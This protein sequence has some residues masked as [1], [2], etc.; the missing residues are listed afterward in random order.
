M[1]GG[2]D[3]YGSSPAMWTVVTIV[4]I[5]FILGVLSLILGNWLTFGV[6]IAMLPLSLI[7]GKVMSSIG[8]QAHKQRAPRVVSS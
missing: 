5:A 6:A 4:I 3:D 8:Y 1:S 7:V 2:H